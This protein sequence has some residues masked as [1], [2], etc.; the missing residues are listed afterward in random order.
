MRGL[1]GARISQA[2]YDR[3]VRVYLGAAAL[4]KLCSDIMWKRFVL[5]AA[6]CTVLSGLM[7][8]G[9]RVLWSMCPDGAPLAARAI[10]IIRFIDMSA[11]D[12]SGVRAKP[13]R[14]PAF[15]TVVRCPRPDLSIIDCAESVLTLGCPL[16]RKFV[17][18]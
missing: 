11:S 10:L 12:A 15:V 3:V 18:A 13:N 2:R 16:H 8:K 7:C 5:T 6:R 4:A 1:A 9:Y 17:W 14:G